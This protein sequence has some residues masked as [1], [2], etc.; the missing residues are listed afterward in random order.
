MLC[1]CMSEYQINMKVPDF[2]AIGVKVYNVISRIISCG[3]WERICFIVADGVMLFD[4]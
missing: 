4:N 3:R 1:F 2:S